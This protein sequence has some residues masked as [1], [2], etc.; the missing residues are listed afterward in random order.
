MRKLFYIVQK[1]F[2]QIFR[3]KAILSL[4]TVVLIMQLI[5]LSYAA[6]NE[7]KNV[8][9]AIVNQDN[10]EYSRLSTSKIKT[11]D[12]FILMDA[13]PSVKVAD[14][15]MQSGNADII[16]TIPPQFE[17]NFFKHKKGEVQLLANAVNG[18][19]ATAGAAYLAQ[20][21][22]SFNQEIRLDTVP[23]LA[24]RKQL[25]SPQIKIKNSNWYNQDLSYKDFMIPGILGKL[26]TLLVM[27]LTAMNIVRKREI[28]TIEQINVRVCLKIKN[29]H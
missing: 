13:P 5:I 9:L 10:S 28:G 17:K 1:E 19:Q 27:L 29:W 25:N 26:A 23:Q 22:Q 24:L 3:N 20:I 11:S 16:L 7:V 15:M 2:I 14:G 21:I 4:M 18:Q 12:R 6:S 8:Q